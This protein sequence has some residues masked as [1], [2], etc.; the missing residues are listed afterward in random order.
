M[1]IWNWSFRISQVK[2]LTLKLYLQNHFQHFFHNI[3][4][5]WIQ[6]F[7]DRHIKFIFTFSE[8]INKERMIMHKEERLI[9]WFILFQK[10]VK[11]N[12]IEQQDIYNMN[13]KEFVMRLLSKMKIICFKHNRLLFTFDD[14]REWIF[15]IKCVNILSEV[16]KM[17][18]IFKEKQMQKSWIKI[19][20][21]DHIIISENEW[22]NNE[23]EFIWLKQCFESKTRRKQKEQYR[24]F[25]IDDH[26][27]HLINKIIEFIENH[28]IIILCLSFHFI[29][30]LQPLNVNIFDSLAQIYKNELEALSR[31]SIEYYIDKVDFLK[32]YQKTRS[33]VMT[34]RVIQS[35]WRKF[36]LLS[37]NL[38]I[39]LKTLFFRNLRSKTFFEMTF[40]SSSKAS[41]T[42][43]FTLSND[44]EVNELIDKII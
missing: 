36:E 20:N 31:M 26:Q 10:T 35:A 8:F 17:W 23:I 7:L 29:N 18:I 6:K 28:K 27:S 33:T 11:K 32:I 19:L 13:E 14:N 12:N 43:F 41:L 44:A 3:R 38:E 34:S 2:F 42:I 30:L 25:I 24:L 40:T 21:D 22:I 15:F 4:I 5:N 9:N 37:L 39:V 16:L 1:K